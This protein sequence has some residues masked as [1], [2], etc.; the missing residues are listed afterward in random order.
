MKLLNSRML[1]III[2]QLKFL[3][4]LDFLHQRSLHYVSHCIH[5][6]PDLQAS[7]ELV[8]GEVPVLLPQRDALQANAEGSV[9]YFMELL[10]INFSCA[11]TSYELP[12]TRARRKA[13][14]GYG[15]KY[16][17]TNPRA[18]GTNPPPNNYDIKSL[19]RI[20]QEKGN[21]KTFGLSREVS[22]PIY[23]C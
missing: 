10:V 7:R 23:L 17:F 13:G 9:S 1:E 2:Q 8:H 15:G 4:S 6:G 21:G 14:F 19:F 22:E 11:Q 5:D 20:N 3:K 12:S 16:D 18:T